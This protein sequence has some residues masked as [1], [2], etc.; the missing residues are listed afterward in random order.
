MTPQHYKDNYYCRL[1]DK[2]IPKNEAIINYKNFKGEPLKYP[3]PICPYG[4]S[5]HKLR[6]TPLLT[7]FKEKLKQQEQ[8][9][10]C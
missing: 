5:K 7:E 10:K 1:C 2:W 6:H 8:E 9:S 3:F 4:C